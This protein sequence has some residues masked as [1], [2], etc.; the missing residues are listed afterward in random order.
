MQSKMDDLL[1]YWTNIYQAPTVSQAVLWA[2]WIAIGKPH[3]SPH[4]SLYSSLSFC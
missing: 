3:G 1:M 4:R 2:E